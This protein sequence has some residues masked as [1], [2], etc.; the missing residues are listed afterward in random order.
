LHRR[1]SQPGSCCRQGTVKQQQPE[2]WPA[3]SSMLYAVTLPH[4]GQAALL[5]MCMSTLIPVFV[6]HGLRRH[7][8][9]SRMVDGDTASSHVD[10][11]AVA[12]EVTASTPQNDQGPTQDCLCR[13]D[14][15][16]I[17]FRVGAGLSLCIL[18]SACCTALCS[19]TYHGSL[20]MLS[21]A[22]K[23]CCLFCL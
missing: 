11:G 8:A 16:S 3:K 21:S 7:H 10:A 18:Q 4:L 23:S 20:C 6:Q 1:C 2:V 13:E 5:T 15:S 22:L 9:D 19:L 12:H 17:S 14:S